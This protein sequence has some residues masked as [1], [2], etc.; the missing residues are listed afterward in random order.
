[1]ISAIFILILVLLTSCQMEYEK[2]DIYYISY[3]TNYIYNANKEYNNRLNG[4]INDTDGL[5]YAL[6]KY[7]EEY[8]NDYFY[9][10]IRVKHDDHGS[11]IL[12]VDSNYS[13][14][15][16]VNKSVSEYASLV[17]DVQKALA[18]F[19]TI[20]TNENDIVIFTFSGHGFENGNLSFDRYI[21]DKGNIGDF[22]IDL[23]DLY[24][25]MSGFKGNKVIILDSCF[26]GNVLEE[27]ETP[28]Y[29]TGLANIYK[30]L[31]FEY[32]E[33]NNMYLL[34]SSS[35]DKKSYESSYHGHVHGSMIHKILKHL[36]FVCDTDNMANGRVSK[37][38]NITYSSICKEIRPSLSNFFLSDHKFK[39][40]PY[41]LNIFY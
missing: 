11:K 18:E 8:G 29:N 27:E 34:A 3:A 5:H 10:N 7:S 39:L 12:S 9:S 40:T 19:T 13:G 25:Y 4:T 28:S 41:N 6:E 1:M 22:V 37:F 36:N 30:T 35:K 16:D 38:R 31:D 33:R 2:G 15:T 20:K 24:N 14:V 21:N 23:S 26:S 32:G 17:D